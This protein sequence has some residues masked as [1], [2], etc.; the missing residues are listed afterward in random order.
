MMASNSFFLNAHEIIIFQ[1]FKK[2]ILLNGK[3][4]R[5]LVHL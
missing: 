2:T 1:S 5:L 3:D 4:K